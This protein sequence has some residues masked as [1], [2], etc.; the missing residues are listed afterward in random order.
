M[1]VRGIILLAGVVALMQ[2]PVAVEARILLVPSCGGVTHWTIIPGNPADPDER[3]DCAKA[4]HAI[5]D[6]RGKSAGIKKGC[7]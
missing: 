5:T 3:R 6:R 4:C 1:N 7:C 2:P